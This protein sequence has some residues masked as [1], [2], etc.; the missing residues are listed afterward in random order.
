[1]LLRM[2]R[3]PG[4]DDAGVAA[5][6][7]LLRAHAAVLRVLEGEVQRRTGLPLARYDVLLE[8]NSADE[9]RLRMQQL[10]ERVVLSRTRVSRLVGE[11]ADD[12][13]VEQV[14]DP[15]D[16]RAVLAVI[17]PAGHA[18]LRAAAP[19][20]LQGIQE[21]FVRHLSERQIE[22]LRAALEPVIAAHQPRGSVDRAATAS[23][24]P[25]PGPS[26]QRRR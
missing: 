16:G 10:S 24:R 3:L 15:T 17:T 1:M 8:L 11:M 4:K 6:A 9:G 13:L 2:G 19:V 23:G 25:D 18:A 20:Y 12:G 14:G 26:R 22:A 5:W 21:H 7:A